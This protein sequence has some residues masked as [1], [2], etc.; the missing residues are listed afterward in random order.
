MCFGPKDVYVVPARKARRHEHPPRRSARRYSPSP[1]HEL[2][3]S[4]T[5][6]VEDYTTQPPAVIVEQP[7]P[8]RRVTSTRARRTY[9]V[10]VEPSTSSSSSSSSGHRTHR[11]STTAAKRYSAKTSASRPLSEYSVHEREREIR[12][13]RSSSRPR[14]D[15]YA[16]YQYVDAPRRSERGEGS[17]RSEGGERYSRDLRIR[18]ENERR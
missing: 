4:R 13:E 12:R 9:Q 1:P 5:R 14:Q 7:D 3:Y 17:R 18:I 15:Q 16:T 2:Q 8:P 11:T 6:V 10:E